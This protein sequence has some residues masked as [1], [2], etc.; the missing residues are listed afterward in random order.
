ML[1]SALLLLLSVVSVAGV[2]SLAR[3]LGN[4]VFPVIAGVPAVVAII[5]FCMPVC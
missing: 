3:V 1:L 2:F 5:E 4:A